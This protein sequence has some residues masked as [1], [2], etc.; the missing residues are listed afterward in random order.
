ME[1]IGLLAG[2]VAHDFNNILMVVSGFSELALRSLD[3]DHQ[4]RPCIEEVQKASKSAS[5]LTRQLLALSRKQ[6]FR[7]QVLNLN[8]MIAELEKILR[9]VIGESIEL[10]TQPGAELHNV[11]ADPTQIE[12][13]LLNL[14]LNSRD[15][16]ETTGKI[17]IATANA[18]APEDPANIGDDFLQTPHVVIIVSDTGC[19]IDEETQ[20]RMFEPFFSTKEKGKGTGLG[21]STVHGIVKHCGGHIRVESKPGHGTT[22]RIYLPRVTQAIEKAMEP[23]KT[24]SSAGSETILVVEDERDVRKITCKLLTLNGYT[25]LEASG[26]VEALAIFEQRSDPIDLLLTDVIMPVMNGRE[27]YEQIALLDS[28][29][30][31]LYMSGYT[32]GVIDDG[33]ILP[34]GVNFLQKPFAPDALAEIVRKILDQDN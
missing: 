17:C 30:K 20:A 7:P 16:I 15:A 1:A 32:N 23:S 5:L 6:V 14:T 22:F 28:G 9:S 27:L 33:G 25:V 3:I 13:V 29:I 12:Q 34:D 24:G 19:G 10:T 31:T 26:P 2:G 11:L 4:A 21:L 8:N 18:Y